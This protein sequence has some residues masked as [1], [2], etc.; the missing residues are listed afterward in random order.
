MKMILNDFIE[1]Y[2]EKDIYIRDDEL[3][4]LFLGDKGQFIEFMEDNPDLKR[5]LEYELYKI[6]E[7]ERFIELKIKRRW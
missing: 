3:G 1:D 6:I 2:K 4:Y 5:I 7:T